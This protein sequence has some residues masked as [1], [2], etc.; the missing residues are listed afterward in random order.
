MVRGW[1]ALSIRRQFYA[2]S[3]GGVK[4]ADAL[5]EAQDQTGRFLVGSVTPRCG[6]AEGDRPWTVRQ[7]GRSAYVLL[8]TAPDDS[9][10]TILDVGCHFS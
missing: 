1:R 9:A 7:C 8:G 2:V 10:M 5:P 3:L 4:D 6:K